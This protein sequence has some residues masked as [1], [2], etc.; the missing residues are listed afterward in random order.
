MIILIIVPPQHTATD[1]DKRAA[2]VTPVY[3]DLP[4]ADQPHNVSNVRMIISM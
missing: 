4:I 2:E 1:L 3:P